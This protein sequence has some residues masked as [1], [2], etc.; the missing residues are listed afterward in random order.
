[1]PESY[2]RTSFT[3]KSLG[4]PRSNV[5]FHSQITTEAIGSSIPWF[6]SGCFRNLTR[7]KGSTF[8]PQDFF[9]YI[10]VQVSMSHAIRTWTLLTTAFLFVVLVL[11]RCQQPLK[12]PDG[13]RA[14]QSDIYRCDC[15]Y[16]GQEQHRDVAQPCLHLA[17]RPAG[18]A[19]SWRFATLQAELCCSIRIGD[20]FFPSLFAQ[21]C[22]IGAGCG[23]L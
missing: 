23:V 13:S 6:L 4:A 21:R 10:P 16:G 17:V 15:C 20:N 14:Y 22:V 9:E 3:G 2:K 18:G 19:G 8:P 11:E 1:M 7:M 12:L 5:S